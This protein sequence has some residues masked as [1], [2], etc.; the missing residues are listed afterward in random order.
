MYRWQIALFVVFAWLM[1]TSAV[2]AEPP[3]SEL[4]APTWP[5]PRP[6]TDVVPLVPKEPPPAESAHPFNVEILAGFPTGVRAQW[7]LAQQENHA[8]LIEGFAGLYL[9]I[10]SAGV[11]ARYTSAF[12]KHGADSWQLNPGVALSVV[13]RLDGILDLQSNLLPSV[14]VEIVRAHQDESGL[15]WEWGL[16]LGIA[17]A[18]T[19]EGVGQVPLI[20]VFGGFRF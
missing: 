5:A 8:F 18:K 14:D 2:Q 15:G 17:F 19:R 4:P 10:P 6:D 11:G 16:D 12:W 7:A 20:S 1:Q 13:E 9:I 3:A